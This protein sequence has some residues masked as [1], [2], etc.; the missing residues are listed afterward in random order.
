MRRSCPAYPTLL[1][2]RTDIREIG[3]MMSARKYEYEALRRMSPADKL[4]VM[5]TMIRQAYEL[6][7][8]GI[9]AMQPG[10]SEQQVSSRARELVGRDRS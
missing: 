4:T 5:R 2:D 3:N 9:R 10:L 6:K 1:P 7:A 8:A